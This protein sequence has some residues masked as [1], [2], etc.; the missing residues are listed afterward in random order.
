MSAAGRDPPGGGSPM[1]N[2]M[3]VPGEEIRGTPMGDLKPGSGRK[4]GQ[5]NNN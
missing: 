1:R 3:Q 5:T 2:R 4:Y